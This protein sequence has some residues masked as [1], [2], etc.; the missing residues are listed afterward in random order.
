MSVQSMGWSLLSLY[1]PA[2]GGNERQL[3][4]AVEGRRPKREKQIM[5]FVFL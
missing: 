4:S 5:T 2:S 1:S 3:L